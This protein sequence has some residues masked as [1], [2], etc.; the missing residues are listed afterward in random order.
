M[1]KSLIA[2]Q[3]LITARVKGKYM[4]FRY[5]KLYNAAWTEQEAQKIIENRLSQ[6]NSINLVSH[7]MA[8]E[9][10]KVPHSQD[11]YHVYGKWIK[12]V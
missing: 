1:L 3:G 12:T 7:K 11:R 2:L 5:I 6:G 4:K 10:R 9:L 8:Y